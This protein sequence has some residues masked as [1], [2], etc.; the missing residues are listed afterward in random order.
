MSAYTYTGERIYEMN[1]SDP[2][3]GC[4]KNAFDIRNSQELYKLHATKGCGAA[5]GRVY[6]AIMADVE[7]TREVA[8]RY[9]LLP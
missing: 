7:I 6:V 5:C 8:E 1:K 3:D 4:I 2:W 9:N